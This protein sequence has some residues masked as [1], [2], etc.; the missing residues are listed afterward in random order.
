MMMPGNMGMAGMQGTFVP[1]MQGM[2][3]VAPVMTA[4]PGMMPMQMMVS[5]A[6]P[7]PTMM[8]AMPAGAVV[9]NAMSTSIDSSMGGSSPG[10]SPTGPR[11]QTITKELDQNGLLQVKYIVDA[12]K[13]KANDKA[14]ISPP[15]E[16]PEKHDGTFR[17][18]LN[19]T[20]LKVRGGAT[21]KNSS[22]KGNVQLKCEAHS[23]S[24]IRFQIGIGDGLNGRRRE[25]SRGPVEHNLAHGGVCGL[26]KGQEEWDFNKV[27]DEQSKTFAVVLGIF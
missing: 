5:N 27:V 21:F 24:S 7:M 18:I 20:A 26:P 2:Q 3:G 10:N 14:V 6:M 23:E 25:A 13:L 4:A 9:A 17:I 11:P 8:Q 1:M 12:R 16:I 15:F 22:G 19:P